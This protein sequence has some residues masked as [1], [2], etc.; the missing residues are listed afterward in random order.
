MYKEKKKA[1]EIEGTIN[2]QEYYIIQDVQFSKNYKYIET[3]V[4]LER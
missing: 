4:G 1:P 2:I 3:N